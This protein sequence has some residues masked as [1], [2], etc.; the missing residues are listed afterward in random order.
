MR[1]AKSGKKRL[2]RWQDNPLRRHDD[3][4][5]AWIVLAVWAFIAVGGAVAGVVTARAADQ[6]FAQ[7]RADRRPVQA[8][9][10]TGVPKSTGTGGVT[11]ERRMARVPWTAPDRSFR[12][13]LTRVDADLGAGTSVMVWEDG[14]GRLVAEPPDATEAAIEAGVLGALAVAAVA[15]AALGAG[16]VARWRLDERRMAQWGREWDLVGPRWGHRTG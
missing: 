13:G 14:R 16:A 5:E 15:G 4:V 12:T 7:Q 2:W 6:V 1:G 3:I 9:L 10:L 11:D 8:V